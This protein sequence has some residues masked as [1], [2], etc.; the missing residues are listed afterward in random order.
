MFCIVLYCIQTNN[1]SYPDYISV[2]NLSIASVKEGICSPTTPFLLLSDVFDAV[3]IK[4]SDE[5]FKFMEE[6]VST[7]KAVSSLLL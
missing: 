5:V 6:K 3:T 4:D 7:W 1:G 2:I